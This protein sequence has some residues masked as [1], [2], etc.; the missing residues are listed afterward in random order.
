[1]RPLRTLLTFGLLLAANASTAQGQ[2]SNI[3]KLC[4]GGRNQ[5][6]LHVCACDQGFI[7]GQAAL[8]LGNVIVLNGPTTLMS[9]LQWADGMN[10]V[11]PTT[12]PTGPGTGDSLLGGRGGSGGD[13]DTGT[14]TGTG[15][16]GERDTDQPPLPPT[17]PDGDACSTAFNQCVRAGDPASACAIAFNACNDQR[18]IEDWDEGLKQGWV[19]S[20]WIG[21]GGRQLLS[22]AL[23]E[24]LYSGKTFNFALWC[25]G[26]GRVAG[27]PVGRCD[28]AQRVSFSGG[29]RICDGEGAN[30]TT[31][32]AL[33]GGLRLPIAQLSR[34]LFVTFGPDGNLYYDGNVVGYYNDDL[35]ST[36]ATDTTPL[37]CPSGTWGARAPGTD[38]AGPCECSAA[39]EEL[40]CLFTSPEAKLNTS[41]EP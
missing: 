12:P 16:G 41:S 2:N 27:L 15:T 23:T 25:D 13:A 1:M 4:Y 14:E 9:C 22:E 28:Q 24:T 20:D 33:Q 17:L 29:W 11:S 37:P 26:A 31:L 21:A 36:P 7:S 35:A 5:M 32:P 30:C 39:S 18:R 8:V 6:G 19:T 10:G 38:P 40:L 3:E 34:G